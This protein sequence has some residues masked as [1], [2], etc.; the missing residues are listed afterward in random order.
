MGENWTMAKWIREGSPLDRPFHIR[1]NPEAIPLTNRDL[2]TGKCQML[3]IEAQRFLGIMRVT[4]MQHDV[5]LFD[6]PGLLHA[7]EEVV[8]VDRM[9]AGIYAVTS[10]EPKRVL[11][12]FVGWMVKLSRENGDGDIR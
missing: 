7:S 8:N 12:S 9:M 11:V 2:A 6:P 1:H 5:V 3:D 10:V 4:C